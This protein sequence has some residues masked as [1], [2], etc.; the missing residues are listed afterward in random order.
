MR[1]NR[2]LLVTQYFEPEIGAPQ[3]R[4]AALV[5]E[6][7]AHG[8]EVEVVTALPNHP[9][10]RIHSEYRRRLSATEHRHGAT[11]RRV[12]MFGAT[13]AGWRRMVSY[14]SFTF[15]SCL[16]LIRCRRPDVILVES[17]PPFPF[18]PARIASVVWRCPVVLNVADLW[19][20]SAVTLGV[21]D[22]GLLLRMM[23]AFERWVNGSA[24][25]VIAVT[26][27]IRRVLLEEK[28]LAAGKVSF[29]PNGVDIEMFQP[30][31]PNAE[32][33][34]R[35]SPNGEQLI[36]YAGTV[37]LAQGV[38][39]AIDAM[40]LVADRHPQ[41]RLLIVGAGSG[42]AAVERRLV[43]RGLANVQLVAPVALAEVA[44][45]YSV[46]V[47]GLATLRDSP[48]FEGARPSKIFPILA[49]GKPV[50]Y[51]GAGEGARLVHDNG[52]GVVC[53]PEDP[54]AL[55]AAIDQLL[56][57]PEE[58]TAMGKRGRALVEEQ[59][60]WAALVDAWLTQMGWNAATL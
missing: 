30:G 31:M 20:D 12:W 4:L 21:L 19:P 52:V 27:G 24:A 51:S 23:F 55:A 44:N 18:L 37:G 17:P 26:E 49:S 45:L 2:L 41:A 8:M 32:V 56:S 1:V 58:A 42:L 50:L 36:V 22:D 10:G 43:E 3:V 33:S 9:E 59:F 6:L 48:L 53:R 15:M 13:G 47:A 16:A 40:V 14:L 60:S 29:L 54:Q 35:Y 57:N 28:G 39:V 38:E 5:R 46:A 11:V 7:V 25:N 34:D